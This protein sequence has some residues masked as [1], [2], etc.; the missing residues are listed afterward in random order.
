MHCSFSLTALPLPD[1]VD[2]HCMVRVSDTEVMMI[3]GE[4]YS[5]LEELLPFF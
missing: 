1:G 4:D 2:E 5:K 3:G